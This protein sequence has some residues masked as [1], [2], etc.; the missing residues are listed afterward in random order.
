MPTNTVSGVLGT[1]TGQ[2][3]TAFDAC[4]AIGVVCLGITIVY[5][6]ANKWF[7]RRHKAG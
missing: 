6:L 7:G 4:V 3:N 2:F 1:V 5:G